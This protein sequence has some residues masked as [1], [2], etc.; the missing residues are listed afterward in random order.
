MEDSTQP[1]PNPHPW[2]TQSMGDAGLSPEDII[3]EKLLDDEAVML[4]TGK[5]M[6]GDDIYSYLKFTMK[7]FNALREAM[8]AGENFKPSD[9]GSVISAGR[10]KPSQQLRDEMHENYGL[11]DVPRPAA[12]P[13]PAAAEDPITFFDEDEGF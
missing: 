2:E 4:V 5:N 1:Q 9:Y 13:A 6:F 10:G 8:I 12:E 3:T 7:T 11:V